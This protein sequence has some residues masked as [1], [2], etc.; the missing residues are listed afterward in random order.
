M[1]LPH[2][3]LPA[4]QGIDATCAWWRLSSGCLLFATPGSVH[5][6]AVMTPDSAEQD[7]FAVLAAAAWARGE[8]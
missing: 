5:L 2:R 1:S 4:P 8:R 7:A 3:N 6:G